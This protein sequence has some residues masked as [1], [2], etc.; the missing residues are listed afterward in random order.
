MRLRADFLTGGQFVEHV[1]QRFVGTL[2]LMEKPLADRQAAFFHG[3]VE[4]EQ[5]L[6]Q[7][8]HRVQVGQVGAFAEGGQFIQQRAELLAFAGMLLPT[9]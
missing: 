3:T 7:L 9:L 8:I 5:R 4:V 2:S 1:D 6:A